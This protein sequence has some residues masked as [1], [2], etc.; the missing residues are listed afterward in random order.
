MSFSI[1]TWSAIMLVYAVVSKVGLLLIGYATLRY[2]A[3][4]RRVAAGISLPLPR[5]PADSA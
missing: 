5:L 2:V 3:V 4:R 1:V